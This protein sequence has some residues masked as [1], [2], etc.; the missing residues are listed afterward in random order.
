M[1]GSG[2]SFPVIQSHNFLDDKS[3]HH[4]YINP[5]VL[6]VQLHSTTLTAPLS[7]E[8][9]YFQVGISLSD[10]NRVCASHRIDVQDFSFSDAMSIP[11]KYLFYFPYNHHFVENF[12]ET[13]RITFQRQRKH[14]TKKVKRYAVKHVPIVDII[15]QPINGLTTSVIAPSVGKEMG[16]VTLDIFS[17]PFELL[18]SFMEYIKADTV[19]YN[20]R[21]YELSID[22]KIILKEFQN[23]NKSVLEE[24]IKSKQ[25]PPPI[26]LFEYSKDT[27]DFVDF[28]CEMQEKLAL[29]FHERTISP[30]LS[31]TAESFEINF[32]KQEEEN[33]TE[34]F[35]S[36]QPKAIISRMASASPE[37][38]KERERAASTKLVLP[39]QSL[40]QEI[41]FVPV[42]RNNV[43][44]LFNWLNEIGIY[45]ETN[46]FITGT[47]GFEVYVLQEYIKYI[48]DCINS[49]VV[50]VSLPL[51]F[52]E[53]CLAM[54]LMDSSANVDLY[55][56]HMSYNW[57]KFQLLLQE[58]ITFD[59]IIFD[60]IR[61]FVK[62]YREKDSMRTNVYIPTVHVDNSLLCFMHSMSLEI[63]EQERAQILFWSFD[64]DIAKKGN[65]IQVKNTT[66]Y[67]FLS[68]K[69]DGSHGFRVVSSKTNKFFPLFVKRIVF[70]S[71]STKNIAL[72]Y[73]LDDHFS[74]LSQQVTVDVND[75]LPITVSS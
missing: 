9:T 60:E 3:L 55:N 24:A 48:N 18:P 36:I 75:F 26:W 46:V 19:T 56:L 35:D 40:S 68:F 49:N 64:D 67:V 59:G 58:R 10:H 39:E 5:R 29:K 30:F 21:K 6:V 27:I 52:S 51:Q 50:F 4:S 41:V 31:H 73:C 8:S 28:F 14:R 70:S 34:F 66:I 53:G 16:Q 69:N 43:K 63:D 42:Q 33:F 37:L 54:K 22:H 62:N 44:L 17:I 11:L 25:Q 15:E 7:D 1:S 57:I 74:G 45:D 13:V 47:V 38:I 71:N 23:F 61:G 20:P 72:S 2:A 65:R 32:E 12:S